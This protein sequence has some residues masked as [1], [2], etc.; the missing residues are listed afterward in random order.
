MQAV[1]STATDVKI[2]QA[3]RREWA[4]FQAW[5]F[6]QHRR[7][8]YREHEILSAAQRRWGKMKN[9]DKEQIQG[10]Q[11]EFLDD[12]RREWLAR[13]RQSQLH[14]EHWVMTPDEKHM[15]QQ[16][17]GWTHKDMVDAYAKE[18]AEMGPM[19]QR[20]DPG[21]L[22]TNE[23]SQPMASTSRF[24][25]PKAQD[26]SPA[27]THWASEL[28]KM[29]AASLHRSPRS[30]KSVELPG[31]PLY[32][33]GALLQGTDLDAV[34][35]SDLE[36]F[37]VRI[38]EEKIREYYS[39]ACEA[40]LHFQRFLPTLEPSK[41]EAA[42]ADFE[43]RMRD[44]A[45]AK[46]R[47]WKTITVKELRRHQAAE[48]ERR[49]AQQR[50]MRPPPRRPPR[51]EFRDEFRDWDFINS[52]QSSRR[53]YFHT[54]SPQSSR[55]DYFNGYQ[56]PQS[57]Y[58]E[59]YHSPRP[60]PRRVRQRPVRDDEYAVSPPLDQFRQLRRR[61]ALHR[62]EGDGYDLSTW[63]TAPFESLVPEPY[64]PPQTG[65]RS[66]LT[67]W[68]SNL[69]FMPRR[70]D[71][72]TMS[73]FDWMEPRTTLVQPSAKNSGSAEA[74]TLT[75]QPQQP[76]RQNLDS[77]WGD[78]DPDATVYSEEEFPIRKGKSRWREKLTFHRKRTS[79]TP[80]DIGWMDP[81]S[82]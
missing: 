81:D 75:R 25:H 26:K 64:E 34:A 50:A 44:L 28:A 29:S 20:V 35:A 56:S 7:L 13:V 42:Q 14:L 62:G 54:A 76:P 80:S 68:I 65:L 72:E 17:L 19:Y 16:T 1:Y 66:A 6:E 21:T 8:E 61:N 77:G 11:R 52:P 73:S 48:M 45:G 12:A 69:G 39:E 82:D 2:H 70:R 31:M 74:K 41:R 5:L 47:E 71:T 10:M 58:L 55:R 57:E 38:S 3:I 79:P 46:E 22:G 67:R 63:P 4:S 30:P 78:P 23:P 59:S 49:A 18:Q 32:F 60:R 40:A 9:T 24:M 33:V 37:A 43:R 15:L 51:R 36:A 27:Y 53:D